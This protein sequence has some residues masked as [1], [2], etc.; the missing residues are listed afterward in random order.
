LGTDCQPPAL[1][2]RGAVSDALAPFEVVAD[3]GVLLEALELVEGRQPGILVVEVDDVADRDVVLAEVVHPGTAGGGVVERPAEA[4]VDQ[5]LLELGVRDLPDLLD[6]DAVLLDI[7]LGVQAVLGLD[8]LGE[9]TAHALGDED[10]LA[11]ELDAWRILRGRLAVLT[12]ADHARDDAR[13]APVLAPD[14]VGGGEAGVDLHP[15]L[16][17]LHSEPAAQVPQRA[18]ETAM[19]VHVLGRR[20]PAEVHLPVRP[21]ND[22]LVLGHGRVERVVEFVELREQL[23]QGDRVHDRTR[24][25]MGAD[26]RALLQQRDRDL[27]ARRLRQLL[28]PDRGAQPRGAAPDDDDVVLHRLALGVERHGAGSP[29][30]LKVRRAS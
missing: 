21:E 4:V 9:G 23:S 12:D 6:A 14:H 30:G 27:R 19:V 24:Q 15:R 29:V 28:E 5:A 18:D 16:L 7:G 11:V 1:I 8:H 2:A 10:V 20:E 3:G 17:R 25:D 26:F 22:Q 13:D